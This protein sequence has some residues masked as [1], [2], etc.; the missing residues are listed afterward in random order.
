MGLDVTCWDCAGIGLFKKL[1][2]LPSRLLGI[3]LHRT[4]KLELKVANLNQH[5]K[6]W[7]LYDLHTLDL[8][9]P[10][11]TLKTP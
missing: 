5:L 4:C 3:P 6:V 8:R 9:D 7:S 1:A 10:L 11:R 2:Q